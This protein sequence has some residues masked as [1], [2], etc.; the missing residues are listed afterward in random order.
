MQRVPSAESENTRYREVLV[1]LFGR[2]DFS[3]RLSPSEIRSL[4]FL[5]REVAAGGSSLKISRRDFEIDRFVRSIASSLFF[6][7][8]LCQKEFGFRNWVVR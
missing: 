1:V 2:S 4:L 6:L 5:S 8:P 7:L 3:A